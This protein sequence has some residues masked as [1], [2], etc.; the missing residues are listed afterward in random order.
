MTDAVNAAQETPTPEDAPRHW[1]PPKKPGIVTLFFAVLAVVAI[2]LILWA[3]NLPPF[4]GGDEVT[5]NA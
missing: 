2:L 4:T 1:N 5:Q 3:W